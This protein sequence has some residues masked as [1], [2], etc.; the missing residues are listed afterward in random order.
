MFNKNEVRW[1][2]AADGSTCLQAALFCLF[3]EGASLDK[4]KACS[5]PPFKA[6]ETLVCQGR[7]DEAAGQ[8]NDAQILRLM[9]RYGHGMTSRSRGILFWVW[10]LWFIRLSTPPSVRLPMLGL[11]RQRFWTQ[12]QKVGSPVYF[13]VLFCT[14][15]LAFVFWQNSDRLAWSSRSGSLH[16]LSCRIDFSTLVV[17]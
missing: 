13:V 1:L 12:S 9:R 16:N 6:L 11:Q 15:L 2:A 14:I 4:V 5:M 3:L 7:I 17:N 10:S 8:T